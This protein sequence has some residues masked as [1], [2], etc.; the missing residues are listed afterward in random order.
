MPNKYLTNQQ[1]L[2]E[3][4]QKLP[5]FTHDEFTI[6]TGLLIKH[7]EEIAKVIQATNPEVHNWMQKRVQEYNKEKN[8]EKIEKIKKL[9]DQK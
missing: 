7:R 1:F 8:D 6:L 4:E 9:L 3:L 2:K 5:D